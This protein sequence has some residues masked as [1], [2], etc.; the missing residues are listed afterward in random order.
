MEFANKEFY[1]ILL[2]SVFM[3]L[4]SHVF[5]ESIFSNGRY[6]GENDSFVETLVEDFGR[7]CP[8]TDQCYRTADASNN[9]TFHGY[10]IPWS[11]T[12]RCK[13]ECGNECCTDYLVSSFSEP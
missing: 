4:C 1:F 7:L 6:S 10:K 9:R 11:R 5:A 3:L 2:G 12:C 8:F 13:Q